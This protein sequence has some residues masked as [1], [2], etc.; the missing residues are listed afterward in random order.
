M[1]Q[2]ERRARRR[3]S[4]PPQALVL[5]PL[6]LGG[7]LLQERLQTRKR[8]TSLRR[9]HQVYLTRK[10]PIIMIQSKYFP[11]S[12]RE[13]F[14]FTSQFFQEIANIVYNT[15]ESRLA[16]SK[17]EFW[18]KIIEDLYLKRGGKEPLSVCL[19]QTL[20]RCELPHKLFEE[21]CIHRKEQIEQPQLGNFILFFG[22]SI[23]FNVYNRHLS[24]L[25]DLLYISYFIS[26][27][28][29]FFISRNSY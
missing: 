29:R 19:E 23:Y 26:V 16:E 6:E 12:V 11:K 1:V 25:E 2:A 9:L 4:Y 10:I 17:I 5:L 18:D 20:H 27:F 24:N 15:S 3:H 22:I 14:I 28:V 21:I 13:D 8:Q 7:T